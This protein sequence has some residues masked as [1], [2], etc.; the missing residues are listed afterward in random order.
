MR[1]V[2]EL[3]HL[4][5]HGSTSVLFLLLGPVFL[6]SSETA[7]EKL[8]TAL[9]PQCTQDKSA[10]LRLFWG[11]SSHRILMFND[12][13]VLSSL[14]SDHCQACA[15]VG[16]WAHTCFS[17]GTIYPINQLLWINTTLSPKMSGSCK[18]FMIATLKSKGVVLVR[19]LMLQKDNSEFLI[20]FHC[21]PN[22]PVPLPQ[23]VMHV[24]FSPWILQRWMA[25]ASAPWCSEKQAQKHKFL[26]VSL[27]MALLSPEL[28]VQ[29]RCQGQ[30]RYRS[31][32]SD[33]GHNS[34]ILYPSCWWVQSNG[35]LPRL[36]LLCS[37]VDISN[38]KNWAGML[39]IYV[40][41]SIMPTN[42][43]G[44]TSVKWYHL[45]KSASQNASKCN[46]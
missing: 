29:G 22:V 38:S 12:F 32:W 7:A 28:L 42:S 26:W 9:F 34:D 30:A 37:T 35:A 4:W 13:Q 46:L 6:H 41:G 25:K 43:K 33:K 18:G 24:G 16:S 40:Q 10:G 3:A 23:K 27:A 21:P 39:F 2:Q 44:D 5:V 45:I 31:S 36:F 8:C 20:S 11:S 1:R 17:P 14:A 19:L 15:F